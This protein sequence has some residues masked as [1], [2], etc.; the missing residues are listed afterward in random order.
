MSEYYSDK[1]Y[2]IGIGGISMSSL[3]LILL[4]RGVTVAGFDFK[5]SDITEALE[6]RGV[7]VH[8]TF[9]PDNQDSFDTVV[10]T[11]AMSKDD[12]EM[13][14]ARERGARI[15]SRAELLGAIMADYRHSIGV[16]GTHGKSTTTGMLSEIFSSAK[17][18]ATVLAG[19][20][21]PSLDSTYRIGR[22]DTA[23]F[24]ACEYKNSYHAMRPS[25]R[26]VLN[27]EL[28]HVD[29]FGNIDNVIASFRTYLDTPSASGENIAVINADNANCLAAAK[30]I[31]TE[32]HTFSLA[33]KTADF[34]AENVVMNG[35][36]ASFTIMAKG[37]PY[38]AVTL[39]VPGMHNVSNAL[40]ASAAA[41][42]CGIPSDAVAA[43]LAAF[44]GV[45][46][47]F[48]TLGHT[49]SGAAIIDD[50]AH[51]PDEVTATLKAARAVAGDGKVYC[52]F[53]PHTYSRF[54]ALME[55]FAASLSAADE[56]IM[57][58][59]YAA[60]EQNVNGT[61]C[62][63]IKKYLPK[64]QYVG[65]FDDIAK[66]VRENAKKGDLVLTMGAGDVYLAAGG[67]LG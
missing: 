64:A 62:S 36:Y 43:G 27:T 24:E 60:R 23:I 8:Y 13:V 18:D 54:E 46:R 67:M 6:K 1:V 48:E 29:F 10:F 30:G 53:Q 32:V 22:G 66:Y 3:A 59:I 14:L 56:V 49:A 33:D 19:A 57:A 58:D 41:Y 21:I 61:H 16:A 11:A 34:Y 15:L 51:H 63:D 26:V 38:A 7:T 2:F 31:G 5:K 35:G 20:I 50:Y 25:I 37:K 4:E 40:A 39:G 44:H 42:L 9:A 65:G 55:S 45:K 52:I 47:R 28:D 17:A 12:P